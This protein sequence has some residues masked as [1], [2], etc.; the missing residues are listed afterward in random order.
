[1]NWKRGNERLMALMSFWME[2]E[3][4]ICTSFP[5]FLWFLLFI[6]SFSRSN[7]VWEVIGSES[8]IIVTWE[9]EKWMMQKGVLF[10]LLSCAIAHL[11]LILYWIHSSCYL[12][13]LLVIP[14]IDNLSNRNRNTKDKTAKLEKEGFITL[15]P[16]LILLFFLGYC[17]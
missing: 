11:L 5:F 1:M 12:L 10:V 13:H 17:T 2:R 16:F 7:I 14:K 9:Y 6:I 4:T 3:S 8:H 15:L